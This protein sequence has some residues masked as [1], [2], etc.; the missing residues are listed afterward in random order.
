[1]A[2]EIVA[3]PPDA[4]GEGRK[5]QNAANIGYDWLRA[6]EGFD[7]EERIKAHINRDSDGKGRSDKGGIRQA[8]ADDEH[9]SH[10]TGKKDRNESRAMHAERRAHHGERYKGKHEFRHNAIPAGRIGI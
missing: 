7:R 3:P 9:H 10:D 5:R 4:P 6:L 1:M 2:I 8:L